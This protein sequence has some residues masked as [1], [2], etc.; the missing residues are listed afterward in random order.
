MS[1]KWNNS[2][3]VH[4]LRHNMV[5]GFFET[6]LCAYCGLSTIDFCPAC[7]VFVCRRCDTPKHWPAVGIYPDSGFVAEGNRRWPPHRR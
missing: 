2:A 3:L 1:T 5:D 7:G 6:G 4:S